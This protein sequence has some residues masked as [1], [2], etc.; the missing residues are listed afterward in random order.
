MQGLEAV[1]AVPVRVDRLLRSVEPTT[2]VV[3]LAVVLAVIGPAEAALALQ[4]PVEAE[5]EPAPGGVLGEEILE[6]TAAALIAP[7]ADAPRGDAVLS[8]FL[9]LDFA[10][11]QKATA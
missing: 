7:G 1:T 9:T 10:G 8:L 5:A 11:R 3:A 2:V 4:G 6:P